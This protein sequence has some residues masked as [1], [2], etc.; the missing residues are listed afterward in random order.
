MAKRSNGEGSIRENKARG[1]WE[2]RVTVGYDTAGK[3]IRKM[4]T[5]RTRRDVVARMKA[6]TDAHD[7][8]QEPAPVDLTV[9]DSTGPR[10][11]TPTRP[12]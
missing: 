2:A 6:L 7:T 5:A 9:R 12:A 1:R 11:S 3:P 4:V 10:P 8:G